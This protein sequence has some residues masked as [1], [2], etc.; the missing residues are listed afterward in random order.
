MIKDDQFSIFNLRSYPAIENQLSDDEEKRVFDFTM[1]SRGD[2][3]MIL[4]LGETIN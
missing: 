1:K 2:Q 4:A 3:T